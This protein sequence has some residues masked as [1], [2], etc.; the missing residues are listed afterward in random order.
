MYK[1]QGKDL[2][3]NV[4]QTTPKA[5]EQAKLEKQNEFI[6]DIIEIVSQYCK[7]IFLI[8]PKKEEVKLLKKENV[9]ALTDEKEHRIYAY[10]TEQAILYG[11]ADIK[12]KYFYIHKNYYRCV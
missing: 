5:N 12:P 11:I 1:R 4:A 8:D 7:Y 10:P 3:V 9:L 6:D 2:V